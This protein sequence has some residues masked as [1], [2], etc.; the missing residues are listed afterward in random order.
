MVTRELSTATITFHLPAIS[1]WRWILDAI[2]IVKQSFQIAHEYLS[3]SVLDTMWKWHCTKLKSLLTRRSRYW[4]RR[5][6]DAQRIQ[7]RSKHTSNWWWQDSES[8]RVWTKN[9]PNQRLMCFCS[10]LRNLLMFLM[11]IGLISINKWKNVEWCQTIGIDVNYSSS[12]LSQL[13]GYKMVYLCIIIII[14][15][16]SDFYKHTIITPVVEHI[17]W[18][19]WCAHMFEE[20]FNFESFMYFES[21]KGLSMWVD[22]FC[23]FFFF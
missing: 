4:T 16:E 2:S 1:K 13:Y 21:S 12:P 23:Y 5:A 6:R 3:W 22:P 20:K 10:C 14:V 11:V 7:Q 8:S 17:T 15:K 18:F 19:L 9:L